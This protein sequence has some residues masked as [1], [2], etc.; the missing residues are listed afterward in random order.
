[1]SFGPGPAPAS[2]DFDP[3]DYE[4]PPR[5]QVRG[6]VRLEHA[7]LSVVMERTDEGGARLTA[8]VFAETE[9]WPAPLGLTFAA[10]TPREAWSAFAAEMTRRLEVLR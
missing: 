2:Q 1:M 9:A 3:S 6:F 5:P 4:R 7:T 10:P 8:L